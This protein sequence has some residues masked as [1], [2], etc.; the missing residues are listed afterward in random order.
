MSHSHLSFNSVT[1]TT[2]FTHTNMRVK[3]KINDLSLSLHITLSVLLFV[4][5]SPLQ[6][7]ALSD[8]H[9]AINS[10]VAADGA[11]PP[12]LPR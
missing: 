2:P 4:L 1:A 11:L 7:D 5:L 8:A 3:K 9:H 6:H 12:A 10:G